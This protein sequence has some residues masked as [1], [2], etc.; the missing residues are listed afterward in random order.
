MCIFCER[1]KASLDDP[2]AGLDGGGGWGG[3]ASGGSGGTPSN[4]RYKSASWAATLRQKREAER[5]EE[6]KRKARLPV[7]VI[8]GFLGSGKT[9]FVNHLLSARHGRKLAVIENE[10]GEVAIDDALLGDGG[11]DRG[12][13]AQQVCVESCPGKRYDTPRELL[14]SFFCS[15]LVLKCRCIR[16]F[17]ACTCRTPHAHRTQNAGGCPRNTEV[18][19]DSLPLS[20][21]ILM[22]N[23]CM[24]CRVRGDLVD[25]LKRLIVSANNAPAAEE[26]ASSGATSAPEATEVAEAETAASSGPDGGAK[27]IA[28]T[29]QQTEGAVAVLDGII[30][31]CSGLDELAPVLQVIFVVF[32]FRCTSIVRSRRE[33]I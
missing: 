13:E 22:P 10:F 3:D 28:A 9:T 33:L 15:Y 20:Q 12:D 25:A 30:L 23:G 18:L 17:A 24:C 7:T 2:L 32:S 5:C 31:E 8:T 19:F 11:V 27:N 4:S 16:C 1:A 21:V 14:C 26:A 29:G 6:L